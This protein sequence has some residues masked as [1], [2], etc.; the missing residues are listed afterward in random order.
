MIIKMLEGCNQAWNMYVDKTTCAMNQHAS[1]L[2]GL[3]P[4]KFM[5]NRTANDLKDWTKD[6]SE[7]VFDEIFSCGA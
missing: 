3:K 2:H 5:F 7:V 6:M 1:R 4:F